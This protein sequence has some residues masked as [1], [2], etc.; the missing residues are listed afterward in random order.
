[1]SRK[2][3]EFPH[4]GSRRRRG[5]VATATLMVALAAAGCG[6]ATTGG[7]SS[8][9]ASLLRAADV[10]NAAAGYR[11]TMR[12]GISTSALPS[13]IQATGLGSFDPSAHTGQL[14]I[15]MS[16]GSNPQVA[17]VLGGSTLTMREILDGQEIYLGLPSGLASKLPGGRPWLSV[18]LAQ[19][20]ANAGIPG[21]SSLI[22]N[23]TSSNPAQFLQYLR[24]VS[25][26]VHTIGSA[27][28]D[29]HR[30]TGYSATID[31]S[32]A[33]SVVP[34]A[35]RASVRQ[36][37]AAVER[38]TG[39]TRVP[40]KVW[41]DAEHLVRRMSLSLTERPA[42]SGQSVTSTITVDILAYGPQP[43][44]QL[45]SASQVTNIDSLTG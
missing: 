4:E 31:L 6:S 8:A 41:V 36:A 29:G 43:K 39:I 3:L 9:R 25:G 1:V 5:A 37:V 34:A 45:P 10:T 27:T 13:P 15:S 11:M 7:A 42:G 2:Q 40:V 30:T 16:F 12:M 18:N 28:I 26:G 32:K 20:A 23:P 17:A 44:P 24:A 19:A 35:R 14:T 33:P 38:L 22:E 21:F